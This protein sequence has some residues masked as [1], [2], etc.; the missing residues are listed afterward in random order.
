M[1]PMLHRRA[2]LLVGAAAWAT[3][4]TGRANAVPIGL[5]EVNVRDFGATGDGTTDDTAAIHAGR[6]AAGVG[7]KVVIP[8]GTYMVS[9]LTADLKSQVWELSDDAVVKMKMGATHILNITGAAVT[10]VGGVFDGA[11]GVSHD[12]S[13]H[14]IRVSADGVSIRGVT[15]KNSPYIGIAAYNATNFRVA[16]CT[17]ANNYSGGIWCRNNLTG[18]SNL[19]GITFT[20]N[21]VDES[22]SNSQFAS[23]IGVYGS[24]YAQRI[25]NVVVRGNR[26]VLPYSQTSGVTGTVGLVNCSDFDV[27]NNVCIGGNISISC[28]N[29]ISGSIANNTIRGFSVMGV[30]LP[31]DARLG[32]GEVNN[33]T[34]A[35]NLLDAD[36]VS[37]SAGIQTSALG[38][39]AKGRISDVSIVGN[40]VRNFVD[41][42]NLIN[43]GSGSVCDRISIV[44]NTLISAV[45]Q[46][47]FSAI[48]FNGDIKGLTATN[49]LIDGESTKNSCG[50]QFLKSALSV[51]ISLNRF[52]NLAVAAVSLGSYEVGDILD[53]INIVD[54]DVVNCGA[55]LRNSTAN[56]ALVGANIFPPAV[57]S[58]S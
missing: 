6:D 37:A 26:I 24:S 9:G 8:S 39:H 52:A 35:R 20:D 33:V 25:S 50:V 41:S 48:T 32:P 19:E 21:L 46:G 43:F 58:K 27:A 13:Q 55:T 56:G 15:V 31:V 7:G 22:T 17:L 47:Q 53:D 11:N 10:V 28:P 12:G 23:G 29:A 42:C 51:S 18:P 1:V 14:G 4:S 38:P 2:F 44:G 34:V 16:Q 30:E 45:L 36:G 54:N 40:T 3:M 5:A 57:S 49:N